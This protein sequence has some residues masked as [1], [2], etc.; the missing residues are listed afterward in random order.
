VTEES[1][2]ALA[3][4]RRGGHFE[5]YVV[6]LIAFVA[7]VYASA[8]RREEWEMV[9]L[10]LGFWAV[11]FVWEM[12]NGLVLHFSQHAALWTAAKKSVLLIYVGLN[13]EIALMFA[14]TPMV[15]FHLLPK[16]R[17]L[18]ILGIPNRLFVP[19][20]FGLFCVGVEVLLSKWGV[21]VWAWGFWRFPHVWLI[22]LAYCGPFA[23][24]VWIHDNV[25]FQ[26]KKQGML[27]AMAVAASA[28]VLLANV[29][30]WV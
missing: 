23:A 13:L 17:S 25:S 20:V 8:I 19:I 1:L 2:T 27:A 3:E 29:L 24:L 12:G 7:Y 26:R 22:A 9:T 28:H 14:V 5:W 10:S 30:H 11:E 16:Q 6:N 18:R 4:L 15:L 21:L